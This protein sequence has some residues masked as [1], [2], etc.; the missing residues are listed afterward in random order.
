MKSKLGIVFFL[1]ILLLSNNA[2]ADE[3]MSPIDQ[4]NA[5]SDEALQLTKSQRYEDAKK[6]LEAFSDK[7]SSVTIK[8]NTFTM[9][10]L[11]IVT[12]AHNEAI[13]ATTNVTMNP[14]ERINRV[15][16]FRLV[17]DAISSTKHPLWTKMEEPILAVFD[18]VKEA[19]FN[20]NRDV[21]HHNL[22]A[23]LSL[24]EI[25]NPSM[26]LD[27]STERFQRLD[28]RVHFIDRYR[29]DI[30]TQQNSM[31]ELLILETELQGIFDDLQADEADPSLWWVIISTGSIIIATLSYVGWRK[32]M[33]EKEKSKNR[34]R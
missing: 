31:K 30:L 9:D 34:S 5:L 22:D 19:A 17:I 3:D 20:G 21:F 28:T 13:E 23:F 26:K 18:E 7:F 29:Q 16:K 33:G 27:V 1:F 14:D 11:R 15:T 12:I 32:Y 6:I 10:E 25:I 8:E 2:L 24:Y 4:L